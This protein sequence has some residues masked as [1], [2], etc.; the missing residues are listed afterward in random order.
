MGIG[1]GL[2]FTPSTAAVSVQYRNSPNRLFAL[3]IAL[4][5]SSFGSLIFPISELPH[6][7]YTVYF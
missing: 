4:S 6:N 1:V 2:V 3:G 7:G 5:G